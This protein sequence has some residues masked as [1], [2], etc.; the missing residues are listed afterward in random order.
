M[1]DE[2]DLRLDARGLRL[3]QSALGRNQIDEARS[4]HLVPAFDRIIRFLG[5]LQADPGGI[6]LLNG[7]AIIAQHLSN[8]P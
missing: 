7:A 6:E 5:R 1:K 8:P 4:A 3:N 2:I